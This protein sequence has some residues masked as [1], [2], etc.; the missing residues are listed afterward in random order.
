MSFF[1]KILDFSVEW[2]KVAVGLLMPEQCPVCGGMPVEGNFFCE[3]CAKGLPWIGERR[4]AVC[5][6]PFAGMGEGDVCSECAA[7]DFAFRRN[8]S[9]FVGEGEVRELVHRLKYGG[10]RWLARPLGRWMAGV[11]SK[12]EEIMRKASGLVP[13]PLHPVKEREREY[14]Q[15]ELLANEV[16]KWLKLPV[17]K[18]LRRRFATQTQTMLTR[19][20]RQRNLRGAFEV[21][22]MQHVKGGNW[23]LV[24][25]VF[26]TGSTLDA[27]AR[28]LRKADAA[29]V[30]A[31][32]VYHA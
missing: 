27:C 29:E 14:N 19:A 10:E 2:G 16:G 8:V 5:S 17:C 6:R 32:T 9:V 15:A 13:V 11:L 18:L 22:Q 25:D 24:D 3:Q 23:I 26:T 12:E 21:T 20:G 1:S 4:C 31:V 7:S 30:W 28:V